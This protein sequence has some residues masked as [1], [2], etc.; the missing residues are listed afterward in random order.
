MKTKIL[1]MTILIS[2]PLFA[3]NEIHG[4]R[5]KTEPDLDCWSIAHIGKGGLVYSASRMLKINPAWS[6][7]LTG[8]VAYT[9]EIVIDGYQNKF[10][11]FE[12]DPEGAD[13]MGD[14]IFNVLGG[15][16]A[17]ITEKQLKTSRVNMWARGG[18]IGVRF[19]L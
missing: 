11:G 7:V 12:P 5:Y 13:L 16:I 10:L 19:S 9:Q 1:L 17:L 14:P 15:A 2:I 6:L 4:F 3:Q 8:I 18:Q